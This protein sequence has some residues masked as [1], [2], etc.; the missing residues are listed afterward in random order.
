MYALVLVAGLLGWLV[1]DLVFNDRKEVHELRL[2][3]KE[4]KRD[5][6]EIPK[7]LLSKQ[8]ETLTDNFDEEKK[9]AKEFRAETRQETREQ[10][11]RFD[12]LSDTLSLLAVR[13]NGR[14]NEHVG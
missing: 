2:D 14:T 1:K 6:D 3:L 10:R 11:Q 8:I 7:K 13:Q 9:E 4:H 12:K 5:C